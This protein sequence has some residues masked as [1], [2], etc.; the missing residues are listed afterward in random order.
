MRFFPNLKS[1]LFLKPG[2]YLR[3]T[4]KDRALYPGL[5]ERCLHPLGIYTLILFMKIGSCDLS[6]KTYVLLKHSWR[7]SW[8]PISLYVT[9]LWLE[10][11]RNHGIHLSCPER[12]QSTTPLTPGRTLTIRLMVILKKA[13]S[14]LLLK[15][16]PW[17][18]T[19]SRFLR[20]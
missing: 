15:Q 19:N 7:R 9:T 4:S 20:S 5:S 16:C 8:L 3:V 14:T 13:V 12:P 10:H 1:C 18:Q 11:S 17:A 2:L 6:F